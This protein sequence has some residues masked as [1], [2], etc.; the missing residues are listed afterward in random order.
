MTADAIETNR[1]GPILF[2]FTGA[3]VGG[4]HISAFNLARSLVSDYGLRCVVLAVEGS[5]I[6]REAARVGLEV[7]TVP[8]APAR[9]RSAVGDLL[10]LAGRSQVLR[11]FGPGTI[12]HCNDLWTLQ[13]WGVPGRLLGRPVIYHHRAFEKS[14]WPNRL[15]F[16][17]AHAV[18]CISEACRRNLAF[19]PDDRVHNIL[20]PFPESPTLDVSRWRAELAGQWSNGE[21]ILLVGFAGNLQRRKRPMFFLDVCRVLADREPCARFVVFGRDRDH[22]A[23]ELAR[24]ADELGLTASV[25][26][27]GFRS[28]P[29]RNLAP[30]DVLLAPALAEPFGR[31][32]VETLLLGIPYVA[33]DDAGH[34]EIFSRWG[35]G[36]LVASSATPEQFAEVVMKVIVAPG[37]VFLSPER[38]RHIA[39]EISP[40]KHA[41]KVLDVY[42]SVL[43]HANG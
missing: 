31:T 27:A 21:K 6:V 12:V 5:T 14:I 11:R 29:E 28:P 7:Q 40:R 39:E 41:G 37:D 15:L 19:L 36:R 3:G 13:S 1:I 20:N 38:R 42:R 17:M 2:P 4:S 22:G 23:G 25:L 10:K 16:G 26:F 35:G 18:I 30:L 9:T 8:G 24:Y 43:G 34:G 33:T 32:L